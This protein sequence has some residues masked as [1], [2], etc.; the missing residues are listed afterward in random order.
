M[1]RAALLSRWHVH[2]QKPD[3]R[4]VKDFLKQPDCQVTC[5]W[6]PDERIAS[7]W[8]EQYQVPW[9]TDLE[10]IL[11]RDDV[12]G[13]IVTSNAA[14]HVE[15]F[16]AAARH[17]KHIFTEKVLAYT[18]EDAMKIKKAVTENNVRFCISF[19]RLAIPQLSYAKQLLDDGVLGKPVA[20]R[21]MCGHNQGFRDTLPQY[22]YD[23]AIT[24]GGAMIDLGFNS[25]YLARYIMGN[26]ISVSSSFSNSVLHR[27]VEDFA[28][29]N[30]QFESGATGQIEATF[31]SP[32][33]SVFELTVYG[34]KGSYY[35]RFGGG[36]TAELN[37]EGQPRQY[38]DIK[39]LPE[40]LKT[41]VAT[42][43][44]C[45]RGEGTE[46]PYDI[47]AAVDMVQYMV[48]A[49]KSAEKNGERQRIE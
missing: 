25:A 4:Y 38:L 28:S 35:A 36:D 48:A 17:H 19:M 5:V 27:K 49:Y 13:V 12:D 7:E 1:F 20:F 10:D 22:W 39:Q 18:L 29:C 37:V 43:V 8:G 14:D 3:E 33:M 34:T 23:P 2:G 41:P 6:D 26:M 32:L 21:C 40:T 24:G 30:V 47:D 42:W 9:S 45:C 11:S 44:A 15:I 16:T 31:D 46:S